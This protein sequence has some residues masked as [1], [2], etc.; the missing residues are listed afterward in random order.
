M[1]FFLKIS[2]ISNSFLSLTICDKDCESVIH[3]KERAFMT[4]DWSM[5]EWNTLW[6]FNDVFRQKKCKLI[7]LTMMYLTFFT[8]NFLHEQ[9]VCMFFRFS[10]I[11]SSF[12]KLYDCCL[13]QFTVFFYTCWVTVIVICAHSVTSFIFFTIWSAFCTELLTDCMSFNFSNSYKNFIWYLWDK[14]KKLTSVKMKLWLFM[15]SSV[16]RSRF[17]QLFWL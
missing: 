5:T 17:A 14:K 4:T 1:S 11:L 15:T 9:S 16:M 6:I 3:W 8:S 10:Q 7:F 12:L 13:F 2:F